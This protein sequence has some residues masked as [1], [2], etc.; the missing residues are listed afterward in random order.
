MQAASAM[1][2]GERVL[3]IT[4]NLAMVDSLQRRL[5]NIFD[6]LATCSV[7]NSC[8]KIALPDTGGAAFFTVPQ[9]IASAVKGWTFNQYFSDPGELEDHELA[10][11][12]PQIR[13][14]LDAP[15]DVHHFETE[16]EQ[17]EFDFSLAPFDDETT[18][19]EPERAVRRTLSSR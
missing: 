7:E 11:V 9:N 2:H 14:R 1:V 16:Y 18:D 8:F 4:Q 5:N 3:I 15:V 19:K 17:V 6:G 12:L 13:L 10:L